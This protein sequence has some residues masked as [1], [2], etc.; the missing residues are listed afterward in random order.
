[1]DKQNVK[2]KLRWWVKDRPDK[3]ARN[4]TK[5]IGEWAEKNFNYQDKIGIGIVEELGEFCHAEL[6]H[7]QKIRGFEKKEIYTAAQKDAL[8]DTMI[9]CLNLAYMNDVALSFD[10]M[11]YAI[12]H[13]YP[14]ESTPMQ[15]LALCLLHIGLWIDKG[16]DASDEGKMQSI[17]GILNSIGILCVQLGYDPVSE[18]FVPVWLSVKK[19]NFRKYPL[20]GLT[21]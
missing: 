16:C 3:T 11:D 5:D 7:R 19:R 14:R 12:E 20:N 9:Y 15:R 10:M 21:K 13:R 17:Q 6:K 18:I 4:Y 1:M 8:A 2:K